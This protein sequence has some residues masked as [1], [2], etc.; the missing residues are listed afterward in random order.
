MK[1]ISVD[2]LRD[3][4]TIIMTVSDYVRPGDYML[5]TPFAGEPRHLS[6]NDTQLEI[7]SPEE[8]EFLA[9]LK[10]WLEEHAADKLVDSL[11]DL[12][13]MKVKPSPVQR[14]KAFAWHRVLYVADYLEHRPTANKPHH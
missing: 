6:W 3:G 1:I 11:H 13:K 14:E 8:L 10:L 2:A 9:Q 12:D 5:P 7:G 4:G